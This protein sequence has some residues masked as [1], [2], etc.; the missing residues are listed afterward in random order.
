MKTIVNTGKWFT[1]HKMIRKQTCEPGRSTKYPQ[2][3]R[4]LDVTLN[5]PEDGMKMS[6]A[7][8]C[9]RS[10]VHQEVSMDSYILTHCGQ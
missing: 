4:H 9:L 8:T 1:V 5:D 3:Q 2:L 6:P 10:K 7:A